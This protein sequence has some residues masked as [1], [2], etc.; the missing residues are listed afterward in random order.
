MMFEDVERELES[1][2]KLVAKCP[3]PLQEKCFEILLQACVESKR[4]A[5][6]GTPPPPPPPGGAKSE[7]LDLPPEVA[8]RFKTTAKRLGVELPRLA[9]LF[10]LHSDPFT[11]HALHVPGKSKAEQTRNIGLLVAAK[12]YL[13]TGQWSAD[14]KEVRARCVDQNCYDG[15]NYRRYL[16]SAK[17]GHFRL[18]EAVASPTP[19]GIKAAE[20]LLGQLASDA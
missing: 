8:N 19:T 5:E 14:L 20:A 6:P 7:E 9:G 4:P 1:I 13:T 10:D 17:P 15:T 12:S 11:F 18:G 3:A 2:L 16:E